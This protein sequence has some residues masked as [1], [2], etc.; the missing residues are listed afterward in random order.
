MLRKHLSLSHHFHYSL[1]GLSH[2]HMSP[3]H[4]KGLPLGI[5]YSTIDPQSPFST[6][7]LEK[8]LTKGV[9]GNLTPP[10]KTFRASSPSPQSHKASPASSLILPARL[11]SERP[12]TSCFQTFAIAVLLGCGDL[13]P[14][15]RGWPP[16]CT[17]FWCPFKCHLYIEPS[18]T[19]SK[20][21]SALHH[22]AL[23]LYA[24]FLIISHHLTTYDI[25]C[26][27]S[28]PDFPCQS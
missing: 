13:P 15:N 23:T 20:S 4:Y 2:H 8:N 7:H 1:P 24:I 14:E 3:E 21:A 16:S 10:L 9:A 6:E 22:R 17:C 12:N 11:A 19:P 18:T 5:P 26:I 25:F 27:C 28:L